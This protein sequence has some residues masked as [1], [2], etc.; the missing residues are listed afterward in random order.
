MSETTDKDGNGEFC[1]IVNNK[2]IFVLGTNWVPLDAFHSNDANRLDKALDYMEYLGFDREESL[3]IG[4]RED[5]ER[6][7]KEFED[8][9]DDNM[10]DLPFEKYWLNGEVLIMFMEEGR[11]T[12]MVR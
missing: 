8:M 11:L 7:K 12:Y 10:K 9:Q 3:M 6:V 1:F 4:K 2:K 5:F